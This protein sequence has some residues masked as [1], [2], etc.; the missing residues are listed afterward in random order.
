MTMINR[1]VVLVVCLLGAASKARAQDPYV[2]YSPV[3]N[4]STIFTSLFG[5]QGLR[6]DSEATLPGEQ[7][8]TAHFTSD[9]QFD[10]SQFSTAIVSQ[11]VSVPL[12]SPGGG[13]TYEFDP[14]LG[15]F[16]RTDSTDAVKL[17]GHKL[18]PADDAIVASARSLVAQGVVKRPA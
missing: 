4:L 3:K 16:R 12:P 15:V 1:I 17:L 7:P 9:F 11:L 6:V 18:I 8:H 2:L 5:P 14:S 13:F 10:F